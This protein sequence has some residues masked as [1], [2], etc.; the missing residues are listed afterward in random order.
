[1]PVPY[2]KEVDTKYASTNPSTL[3]R[4]HTCNVTSNI[5]SAQAD[6]INLHPQSWVDKVL[7][8]ISSILWNITKTK[9]EI[10]NPANLCNVCA[11]RYVKCN[12][13][14]RDLME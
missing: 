1:M 14:R 2:K 5:S 4:K 8:Y 10:S 13:P 6:Q 12:F 9:R 7:P 3:L 11:A